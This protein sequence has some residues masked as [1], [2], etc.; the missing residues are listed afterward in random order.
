[1]PVRSVSRSA[2]RCSRRSGPS[3]WL[4]LTNQEDD[5]G[6]SRA[7]D[8]LKAAARALWNKGKL[9]GQKI[10]SSLTTRTIACSLARQ[11][12]FNAAITQLGEVSFDGAKG[13]RELHPH[14]RHLTWDQ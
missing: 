2:A 14:R 6:D 4:R 5:R 8:V 3:S 11:A 9:I 7:S 10:S 13:S 12:Q 1:M